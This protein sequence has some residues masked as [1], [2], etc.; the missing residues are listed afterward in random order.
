MFISCTETHRLN[1][2]FDT[3]LVHMSRIPRDLISAL[4]RRSPI[5]PGGNK[6]D[7]EALFSVGDVVRV[8][9][10]EVSEVTRKLDL[11]MLQYKDASDEDDDYVV[12]GR[13]PEGDEDKFSSDD[14]D[15]EEETV[16]FDAESTLIWW[17]GEAYNKIVDTGGDRCSSFQCRY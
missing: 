12:E 15:D 1:I 16:A 5:A 13:D 14:A 2:I 11:S 3:G 17:R 10:Q 8:R 4:K 9:T 6:T 7:I